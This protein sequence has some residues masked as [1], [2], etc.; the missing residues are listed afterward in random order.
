MGPRVR[1][2]PLSQTP[3]SR[4]HQRRSREAKV[5]QFDCLEAPIDHPLLRSSHIRSLPSIKLKFCLGLTLH[6]ALDLLSTFIST[7]LINQHNNEQTGG[8]LHDKRSAGFTTSWYAFTAVGHIL[9][10]SKPNGEFTGG[11]PCPEE[12]QQGYP[13]SCRN[14]QPSCRRRQDSIR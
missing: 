9:T 7:G 2:R 6:R 11:W 8:M 12:K 10:P 13:F 5:G 14:R 1:G 4:G 3:G